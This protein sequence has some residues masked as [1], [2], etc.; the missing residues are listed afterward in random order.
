MDWDGIYNREMRAVME[1][2]EPHAVERYGPAYHQRVALSQLAFDL[3]AY[4][5]DVDEL[6]DAAIAEYLSAYRIDPDQADDGHAG[7]Y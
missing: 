1:T 6:S 3:A 7:F 5:I 2:L 4:R